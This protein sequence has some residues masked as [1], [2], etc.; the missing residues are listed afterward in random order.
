MGIKN[1]IDNAKYLAQEAREEL[2][3]NKEEVTDTQIIDGNIQSTD[4]EEDGRGGLWLFIKKAFEKKQKG[5]MILI[6]LAALLILAFC[7]TFFINPFHFNFGFVNRK[8]EIDKTANVVTEIRKIS[9]FTTAVFY[10]ELVLQDVK[11]KYKEH[12]VYKKSDNWYKRQLGLDK[13]VVGTQ[14]DS[15]EIGRIVIIA[16]GN[17]RTGFNFSRLTANDFEVRNDTLFVTLPQA[18]IFDVII[19]PSDIEFFDRKGNYWDEENIREI[20]ANGKTIMYEQAMKENILEK[21]NK[22]G[23]E[24]LGTMFKTFGFKEVVVSIKEPTSDLQFQDIEKE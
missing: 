24:K 22:Y 1:I 21:A 8:T 16:K 18:E 20:L 19:N 11:Y 3:D 5:N 23:I 2:L 13:T 6:I 15:T 17:I 9:E 12:K 14:I 10:K 4:Y 7:V